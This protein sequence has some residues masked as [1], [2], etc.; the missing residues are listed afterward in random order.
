[1]F[2]KL[3]LDP[4]TMPKYYGDWHPMNELNDEKKY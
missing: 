4:K 2:T 1:M 3:K